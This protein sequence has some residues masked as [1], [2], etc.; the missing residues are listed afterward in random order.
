MPTETVEEHITRSRRDYDEW[1][2]A[3]D[4]NHG[5]C[6][7]NCE[8]PQPILLAGGRF[9]CGRCLILDGL[10][11]EMVPCRPAICD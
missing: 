6:P 3:N 7:L 4:C 2:A 5:H 8:H 1:N 10:V 9:V 11:T